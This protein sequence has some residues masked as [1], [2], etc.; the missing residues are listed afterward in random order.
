VSTTWE[1]TDAAY[2]AGFFDGEGSIGIYKATWKSVSGPK[3][4]WQLHVSAS[5]H[6]SRDHVLYWLCTHWGGGVYDYATKSAAEWRI[7]S[8]AAIPFLR[9]VQP[10]LRVKRDEV[11]IVLKSFD[12]TGKYTEEIADLLRALKKVS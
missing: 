12:E 4:F 1:A 9:A 2:A 3:P 5:Q 7:S 10:Y 11:D 8:K 6:Q